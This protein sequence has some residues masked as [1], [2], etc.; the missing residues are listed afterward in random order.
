MGADREVPAV[1]GDRLEPLLRQG[2][3]SGRRLAHRHPYASDNVSPHLA[4]VGTTASGKS[5]VALALARRVPGEDGAEQPAAG[6]ARPRGVDRERPT[7]LVVRPWPLRISTDEV[8]AG[9]DQDDAQSQTG[10]HHGRW[11]GANPSLN[12]RRG[13]DL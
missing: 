12:S 8:S 9:S 3:R 13:K 7:A 4:I 2:D 10:A 6:C 11:C 5:A 1:D